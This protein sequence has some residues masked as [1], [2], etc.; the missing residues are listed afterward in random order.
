MSVAIPFLLVILAG[1]FAAYH[2]WRLAIWVAVSAALLVACALLGASVA[3][4]AVAA[5]LLALVALPLLL[6]VIR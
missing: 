1:A 2:R 6:P 3:A 5:I 4:T